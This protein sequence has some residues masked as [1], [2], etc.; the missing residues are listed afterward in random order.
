MKK[1]ARIALLGV[2]AASALHCGGDD[3]NQ[4]GGGGNDAGSNDATAGDGGMPPRDGGGNPNDSSMP[5]TDA[6]KD[7][8]P[9]LGASVLQHHNHANRDGLFVDPA[10]TTAKAMS[11]ARD[12]SFDGT[13]T[14]NS[15][16]QPLY[17][18]NGP[19]GK[20]AF[21]AVTEEN[22]VYALDET[23]GKPVWMKTIGKRADQQ[24]V[25]G[26]VRP[27]GITGT[28]VIDLARRT[29]YLS[30]VI[31]DASGNL[32]NHEIHAL[33]IDDGSERAGWPVD[34]SK[35]TSGGVPFNANAQ[36]ERGSLVIAGDTVYVPYGGHSGDCSGLNGVSYHGWV[37]G[38]PMDN[39]AGVKAWATIDTES[40]IWAPGGLAS[41]GTNIYATT[42]NG[43]APAMW[44]NSDAIV[45]LG[46]G[47]VFS[48]Q[49]AD[50]YVPTDW[51]SLD[52]ADLDISGTGPILV[53]L[54]GA[55]APQSLVVGHGKDGKMYLV[56]RNNFGGIGKELVAKQ[57][58][59]GEII[60]SPASIAIGN[61]AYVFVY[62]Y[63]DSSIAGCPNGQSGTLAGVKITAGTPPAISV[64]WCQDNQGQGSPIV[65]ST[66]GQANALV[67]SAGAE[68]SGALHAWD[69]LTG[70]P[71]FTGGGAGDQ[72]SGLRH[73]TTLI[74]AKGRIFAQ[75]DDKLYAFK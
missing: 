3:S 15:Y 37:V 16:A 30:V 17:V 51:Q 5:G 49:T 72:I 57:V 41:D 48:N 9:V 71:V 29:M 38:V 65:T 34:T 28:P 35:L 62:G 60:F 14:G 59:N 39:P 53:D 21:Y 73:F 10:F 61:A 1:R 74:A 4:I 36:N 19:G 54:P 8:G 56:D 69:A 32:G 23:T 7:A 50:Y 55:G 66:D 75:A 26:N 63:N 46:P 64:A 6:G 13:I 18:E 33:S 24:G 52:N 11:I 22:N 27:L 68:G 47:A 42:G 43:S 45:R 20:G 40:G 44:Q 67:W 31:A 2:V 25:C 12:T 70:N 58:V